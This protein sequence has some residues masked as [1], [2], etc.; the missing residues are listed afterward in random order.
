MR[1]NIKYTFFSELSGTHFI[2]AFSKL[3]NESKC[4]ASWKLVI[5]VIYHIQRDTT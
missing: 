2:Q 3:M 5:L 4:L 1:I